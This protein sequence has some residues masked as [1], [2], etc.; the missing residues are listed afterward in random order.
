MSFV[1]Y[2]RWN[3]A[4]KPWAATSIK[5][6]ETLEDVAKA[7]RRVPGA[8]L[9]PGA[10]TVQCSH[11]GWTVPMQHVLDAYPRER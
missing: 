5:P 9:D 3:N 10:F 6:Q 11:M 1:T 4:G 8:A 7:F 2:F